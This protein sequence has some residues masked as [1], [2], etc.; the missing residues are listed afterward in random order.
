MLAGAILLG[1]SLAL[2]DTPAPAADAPLTISGSVTDDDTKLPIGGAQVFLEGS[3]VGTL[4]GADG[5]Y[6]LEIGDEV[7]AGDAATVVVRL[8]GYAEQSRT[9][10]IG[11]A[12]TYTVDFGLQPDVAGPRVDD[13]DGAEGTTPRP[14]DVTGAAQS[15]AVREMVFNQPVGVLPMA[16]RAIGDHRYGRA[17]FNTESY[18][19]VDVNGWKTPGDAPLS[20]LSI[21]V[22]RASY[23]NIRRFIT[24][25]R[26]PPVDAVRIEEMINYF[27]YDYPEAR[28]D[29]PFTVSTEVSRAPWNPDHRLVR[30]GI[31][32][33]RVDLEDLPPNNLVFLLDVSGSMQAPNKLP[34]LKRSIRLLVNELR[35]EDRV[36]VVVYAGA[37]GLVLEPTPGNE[38]ERILAAI[39]ELEAGGSTAGGAGLKLAYDVAARNF[40]E[41]GNNRVILATDGDFN[42]GASSDAEMTRLIEQRRDDGTFLT[43]LGFGMGNL[44]DSKMEAIADHG[45]GNYACCSRSRRT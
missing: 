11:E 21:D 39:E 17:R 3:V 15:V 41:D 22:D 29:Q 24:Q 28:G 2:P 13:V 8:I 7:R 27:P 40:L 31:Q 4:T 26:R 30:V 35:P 23:S 5:R 1:G 37:A 6:T 19:Y 16:A 12:A 43:V 20:T 18:A 36:A 32:G 38:R 34:L 44:K 9:V 33:I 25:G 42:V 45:N 10:R 14:G